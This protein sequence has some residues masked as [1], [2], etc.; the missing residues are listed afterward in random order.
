MVKNQV[1]VFVKVNLAINKEIK[2]KETNYM[3]AVVATGYGSPE[4]LSVVKIPIPIPKKNE[5][6]IKV[7]ASNISAADSMMRQ[8][9]PYFAR[10]FTGL[11][12]PKNKTPGTGFAGIIVGIGSEVTKFKV[13]DKVHGE[14]VVSFGANAQY[15][16]IPVDG[17]IMHMPDSLNFQQAAPICD[18]A[19]TA[20]NFLNNLGNIKPGDQVLVNGASGSMGSAAIQIAKSYGAVVTAVC[21]TSKIVLVNSLGADKVIDYTQVD[22]TKEKGKYNIVFDTVGKSSFS[23]CKYSLKKNGL[24]LSPVLSLSL[25][26]QMMLTKFFGNKK[27]RFSATGLMPIDQ[28]KP[29][30]EKLHDG[31]NNGDY[32]TLIDKTYFLEEAHLAHRYVDTGTKKG[33]LILL[34]HLT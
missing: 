9:T 8:G 34:P 30:L 26:G 20:L 16:C 32:T 1:S 10:V 29:L 12:T 24:Y 22:F 21:S 17:L 18:G 11:L 5:V 4:V 28:L 31:F 27:A 33:N 13:S 25:L 23:A 3:Q 14:S 7:M 19:L 2:M 15:L 6:L